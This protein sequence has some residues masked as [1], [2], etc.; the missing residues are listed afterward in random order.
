MRQISGWWFGT[1][2]NI[3]YFSMMYGII[4]P[5]DSY[6]SRWLKH[7]K[8]TNPKMKRR[9]CDDTPALGWQ[10][11]VDDRESLTMPLRMEWIESPRS[12]WGFGE[13]S[14]WWKTGL[15]VF[16]ESVPLQGNIRT[17]HW[18]IFAPRSF[19][20]GSAVQKI[21]GSTFW[22]DTPS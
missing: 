2:W 6:F 18:L 1:F 19:V 7:V 15:P 9:A 11:I 13:S 8:T 16:Q 20:S 17:R 4:L 12:C 10:V 14:G 21:Q 22:D 5:I 3:F